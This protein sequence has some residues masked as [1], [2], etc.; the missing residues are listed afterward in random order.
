M[1]EVKVRFLGSGDALGSGGRFQ[2]C[3]SVASGGRRLLVDCG[4]TAMMALRLYEIDPNEVEAILLTHLHGD[5]FGGL[6]F[7]YLDARHIS[8]RTTPLTVAGPPGTRARVEAT[9]DLMYPGTQEGELGFELDFVE[10]L[11][12]REREVGFVR[13]VAT[14]VSHPSGAPSYALRLACAGREI[15]YSGDTEWLE[16]LVDVARG[17]DLFICECTHHTPRAPYHIDYANLSAR[18][19]SLETKRLVLTHLAQDMLER[20]DE[21]EL[22]CATDGLEIVID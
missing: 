15:A 20:S 10:L 17:T 11:P 16:V 7:L 1:S 18:A 21:I 13:V 5:H 4:A 6:P 8:R 2:T 19:P 12:G 3:I 9:L 22:E 14:E